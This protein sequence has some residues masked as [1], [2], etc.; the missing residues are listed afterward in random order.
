MLSLR[1][2]SPFIAALAATL[3]GCGSLG[4]DRSYI[5]AARSRAQD[6]RLSPLERGRIFEDAGDT[7]VSRGRSAYATQMYFEAALAF[8]SARSA[9]GDAAMRDVYEKCIQAWGSSPDCEGI[10]ELMR[11]RRVGARADVPQPSDLRH[12]TPIASG[13]GGS[14]IAGSVAPS[15]PVPPPVPRRE[16]FDATSCL[17]L[18]RNPAANAPSI[19]MGLH[20]RCS[21]TVHLSFCTM[22]DPRN[23][24]ACEGAPASN[25]GGGERSYGRGSMSVRAGGFAPI[26]PYDRSTGT[27][28]IGCAA[29]DGGS[30]LPFLTGVSPPKGVC[31]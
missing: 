6:P 9:A 16:I 17:S 7:A 27:L 21:F 22:G 2:L 26:I 14:L 12:G 5:D 24:Y 10:S 18:Q 3:S 11:D 23:S 1:K 19:A 28:W 20:N 29:R 25:I 30:V 13:G 31:R 15:R 8:D 4:V